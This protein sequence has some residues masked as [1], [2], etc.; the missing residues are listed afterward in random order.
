[1]LLSLSRT[2]PFDH[3]FFLALPPAD[4]DASFSFFFGIALAGIV[5]KDLKENRDERFLLHKCFFVNK[6]ADSYSP[7]SCLFLHI[8]VMN[9]H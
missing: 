2:F 4:A 1:M 7:S 8:Y 5:E 9:L 6:N 3:F